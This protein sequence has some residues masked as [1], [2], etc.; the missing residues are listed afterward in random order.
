[1]ADDTKSMMAEI[2]A[3]MLRRHIEQFIAF[4]NTPWRKAERAK[5]KAE[6]D[7]KPWHEKAKI[8]AAAKVREARIALAEKIGG[9]S[10]DDY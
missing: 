1:M 2:S 9:R 6:W 10:F 4:E 5:A 8:R 3:Q 7:A